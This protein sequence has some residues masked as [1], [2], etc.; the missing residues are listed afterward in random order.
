MNEYIQSDEIDPEGVE[1][2]VDEIELKEDGKIYGLKVKRA[3]I[4]TLEK[5]GDEPS[6]KCKVN[7]TIV[8]DGIDIDD[9]A[10]LAC[11]DLVIRRQKVERLM[12]KELVTVDNGK[13]LHY[14]SMGLK[15]VD[16]E[17]AFRQLS[18][19]AKGLSAEKK[20]QLIKLLSD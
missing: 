4:T 3:W 16:P 10:I 9:L 15:M 5:V 17:E 1:L 11:K 20:A 19:G 12:S 8:L 7:R 13:D 6:V 14:S 18:S 2:E